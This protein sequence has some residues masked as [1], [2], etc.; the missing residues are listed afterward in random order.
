MCVVFEIFKENYYVIVNIEFLVVDI[1]VILFNFFLFI[2][3]GEK[4]YYK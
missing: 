4:Y 2:L 1:V 3:M